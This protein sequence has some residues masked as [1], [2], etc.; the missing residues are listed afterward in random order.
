METLQKMWFNH[1]VVVSVQM[2][3]AIALLQ[4][5]A[6]HLHTFVVAFLAFTSLLLEK[7]TSVIMVIFMIDHVSKMF[8]LL[9]VWYIKHSDSALWIH[10]MNLAAL[11][12]WHGILP[13]F[14]DHTQ[15]DQQKEAGWL[16]V[17]AN[18]TL[19]AMT[20]CPPSYA[21]Y[22][23]LYTRNFCNNTH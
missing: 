3:M 23:R 10:W 18:I 22:A 15:A 1:T 9:H 7:A 21:K 6:H 13:G 16:A 19:T 20:E 4:A 12:W 8:Y 11:I 2:C 14:Y 17:H 5:A